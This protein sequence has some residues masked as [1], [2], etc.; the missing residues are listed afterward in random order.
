MNAGGGNLYGL[1]DLT[2][3]N[4]KSHTSKIYDDKT[5]T[6]LDSETRVYSKTIID[7]DIFIYNTHLSTDPARATNMLS[8]LLIEVTG[9]GK[10]KV[11]IMGDFNTSDSSKLSGFESAGFVIVNKS[12]W[13]TSIDRILV[14]GM[15]IS[16]YGKVQILGK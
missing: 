12:E 10:D 5:P 7:G 16:G 2:K 15:S 3:L 9:A 11:V 8:E 13:D 14:K 6:S 1:I 4:I